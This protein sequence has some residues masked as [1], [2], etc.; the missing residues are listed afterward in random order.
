MAT[1]NISSQPETILEPV[2]SIFDGESKQLIYV[3][4]HVDLAYASSLARFA[5]SFGPVAWRVASLRIEQI[6]PPGTKFGL[7]WVGDYKPL[8]T[9]VFILEKC[10]IFPRPPLLISSITPNQQ[11]QISQFS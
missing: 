11:P 2:F 1:Y 8:P 6:L 9:P 10:E 7:G 5:G 4:L 3:G